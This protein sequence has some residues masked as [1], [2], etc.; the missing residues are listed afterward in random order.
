MQSGLVRLT[1]KI[2]SEPNQ[3]NQNNA[4]WLV[5]VGAVFLDDTIICFR[6]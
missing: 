5:L 3:P 2:K 6:H 4:V 1:L